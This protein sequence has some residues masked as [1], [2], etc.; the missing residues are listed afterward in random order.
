MT[1]ELQPLPDDIDLANYDGLSPT[2]SVPAHEKNWFDSI[3]A[4]TQP[5]ANI[6]LAIRAQ[7]VISLAEMSN[8]LN[9]MCLWDEKTRKVKTYDGKEIDPITYGTIEPS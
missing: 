6:D 4:N 1:A 8:R 9:M 3:R 2:E 5:N 7:V